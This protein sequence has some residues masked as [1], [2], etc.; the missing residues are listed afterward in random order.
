[1]NF[2]QNKN[3]KESWIRSLFELANFEYQKRLWN[4]EIENEVSDF[5]ECVY[6]YFDD[7]DLDKRYSS[8]ISDRIISKKEANIVTEMHSEFKKLYRTS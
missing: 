3:I 6:K 2:E 4:G 8:F 1:M 7:L 5:T